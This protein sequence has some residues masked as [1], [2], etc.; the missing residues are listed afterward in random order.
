MTEHVP[1]GTIPESWNCID[2]GRN[3][4]P[5][6]LH[7]AGVEAAIALIGVAEWKSGVGI[8]QIYNDK[9]EVYM[10]RRAI[11]KKA[12]MKEWGGCLCIGCLEERIGRRLKPEDFLPNHPY[13]HMPC[14]PRLSNRRRRTVTVVLT[15]EHIRKAAKMVSEDPKRAV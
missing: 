12:G 13:Q 9:T 5:G 1:K 11:W 7:R 15:R 10:V 8:Q 4:A 6:L 3:T 14:T 2:C